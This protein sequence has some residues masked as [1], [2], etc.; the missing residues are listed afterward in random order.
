MV[1][2]QVRLTTLV[3]LVAQ[4]VVLIIQVQVPQVTLEVTHQ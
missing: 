3:E 2:T 4:V 1:L